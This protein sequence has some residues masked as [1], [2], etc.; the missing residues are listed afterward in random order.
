M[1]GVPR[2]GL[3]LIAIGEQLPIVILAVLGGAACG[4]LGAFLALPTVPLFAMAREPWTLD[5]STP[6]ASVLAVLALGL[7]VLGLVAW[8]CGRVVLARARLTRVRETL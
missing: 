4:Q 8:L 5:L 2:R 1:S 6:L 3:G 7:V